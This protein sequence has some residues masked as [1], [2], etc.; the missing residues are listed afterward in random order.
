MNNHKIAKLAGVIIVITVLIL[1]GMAYFTSAHAI[2]GN[3][4]WWDTTYRFDWGKITLDDGVVVEGTV[5]SWQEYE[6]SDAIQVK[7]DGAV[8]YTHLS[9]VVLMAR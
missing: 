4:S 2:W 9:N 6:N 3:Q 5:E 1:I 8:Y 7:I